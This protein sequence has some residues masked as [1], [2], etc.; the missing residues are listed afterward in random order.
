VNRDPL[1]RF[2]PLLSLIDRYVFDLIAQ[3]CLS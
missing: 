2:A 1:H 3:G